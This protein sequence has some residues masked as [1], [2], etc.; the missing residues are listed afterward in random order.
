[1]KG[2]GDGDNGEGVAVGAGRGGAPPLH[3]VTIATRDTALNLTARSTRRCLTLGNLNSNE[4]YSSAG[5]VTA[6]SSLRTTTAARS[7]LIAS[8]PERWRAVGGDRMRRPSAA[9]R[10]H[11]TTLHRGTRGEMRRDR[12]QS[13]GRL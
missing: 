2:A 9:E 10:R 8:G 4:S 1:M 3:A 11:Q 12:W 6:R 7:C 13:A 5:S